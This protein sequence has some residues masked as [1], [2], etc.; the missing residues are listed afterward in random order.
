[1][2]LGFD[3]RLLD[4]LGRSN[5]LGGLDGLNGF[6]RL[7]SFN[8]FDRRDRLCRLDGFSGR[9]GRG[10]GGLGCI[11]R[12]FLSR[13]RKRLPPRGGGGTLRL[14]GFLALALGVFLRRL[15]AVGVT[16][17]RPRERPQPRRDNGDTAAACDEGQYQFV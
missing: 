10:R 8:G 7:R 3:V 14:C 6:D 12:G 1:M 2:R 13:R 15:F 11:R 17:R 9:H 16:S 4:F 5:R